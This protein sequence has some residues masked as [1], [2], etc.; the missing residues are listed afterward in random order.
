MILLASDMDGTILPNSGKDY[1][2]D[3]YP[4]FNHWIEERRSKIK[5]AYVTGRSLSLALEGIQEYTIPV[6]DIIISDVGSSIYMHAYS[7]WKRSSLWDSKISKS[8]AK[9]DIIKALLDPI[10]TLQLQEEKNQTEFKISYY[11]HS[12]VDEDLLRQLIQDTLKKNNILAKVIFSIDHIRNKGLID[13]LPE[14]SGKKNAI[15]FIVDSLRIEPY[16]FLFAGD[17]GND[18]DVLTSSYKSVLVG[19]ADKSFRQTV[20]ETARKLN[21]I[22]STY[23]AEKPYAEAIA[24]ALYHYEF[25]KKEIL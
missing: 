7:E 16:N 10:E 8:F 21:T 12:I 5:I 18:L 22:E 1:N 24:D 25:T 23:I 17:T 15:D 13:I 20:I 11:T 14:E 19:N 9:P 2:K 3:F 4:V 6:P